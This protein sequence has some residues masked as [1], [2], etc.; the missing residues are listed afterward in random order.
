MQGKTRAALLLVA[1][2][3]R[4]DLMMP[5]CVVQQTADEGSQSALPLL[6]FCCLPGQVQ[7]KAFQ[8]ELIRKIAEQKTRDLTAIHP[9]SGDC[10]LH[11]VVQVTR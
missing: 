4:T 7:D 8:G 5:P 10:A 6:L 3:A 9:V 1:H 2:G 11:Y